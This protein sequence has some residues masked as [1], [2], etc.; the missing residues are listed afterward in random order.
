MDRNET[1]LHNTL[2]IDSNGQYR[3]PVTA[4]VPADFQNGAGFL[5]ARANTPNFDYVAADATQRYKSIPDLT[6]VTRHVVF[7]RPQ[8]F[9]MLDNLAADAAH[10]YEWVS[11]F[12]ESVAVEGN[13][14]RGN[15]SGGQI[16][17]VGIIAPQ[18]FQTTTG[19]NG[20]P[21]IRI[22]PQSSIDDIRLVHLLYPTDDASWATKPTW[23]NF[24]DSG[25]AV[26]VSIEP[27]DGSGRTDDILV[28]YAQ[29]VVA[30]SVGSYNF[31]GQV[32]VV[33]RGVAGELEKL[34]VSGGTFLTDQA[35]GKNLA[36]NLDK[37]S[38]FE[39]V[40]SDPLT[41]AVSSSADREITLY[42]P[43]VETLTINGWPGSFT[44]SG[45]YISFKTT[46]ADLLADYQE[47]G[48]LGTWP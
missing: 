1:E 26:V 19:N 6:D 13:W 5:E 4:G 39:A 29:P 21:F 9:L 40:F 37:N 24:D 41:V 20:Q 8:Y 45:D 23:D 34:F 43:Q 33:S 25:A 7:I 2:L 17:G 3:P 35:A 28:S 30:T 44:R 48:G 14:V 10:Q 16:L 12:D 42:A 11:H 32:A 46:I 22:R 15:S 47:A 27:N 18:S 38:P 31:D 36:A